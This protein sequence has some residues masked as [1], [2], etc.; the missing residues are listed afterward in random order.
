MFLQACVCPHGGVSA[1]VHAG[2][3]PPGADTPQS[4]PPRSRHP[5]V[6]T[7]PRE[8][9]PPKSRPLL[10]TVRILLECI[11]VFTCTCMRTAFICASSVNWG[12]NPDKFAH[13]DPGSVFVCSFC[14]INNLGQRT[15]HASRL[16]I[17]CR[18]NIMI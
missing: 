4:R 9:T 5:P 12:K 1:S 17:L 8:Q 16:V 7:A 18:M 15:M 10:R 6:Q 3:H 2:I 13:K 14:H 11:L